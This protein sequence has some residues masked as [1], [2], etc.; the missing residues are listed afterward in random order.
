MIVVLAE[1]IVICDPLTLKERC[2]V[3]VPAPSDSSLPPIYALNDTT[4]AFADCSLNQVIQS[5][6]GR[7]E[8]DDQSYSGQMMNAAKQISK[9]VSSIGES[10]VSSFSSPSS[11]KR[12]GSVIEKGVVSIID[13]TKLPTSKD[14]VRSLHILLEFQ[15]NGVVNNSLLCKFLLY[16]F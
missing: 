5:C 9:T 14:S 15:R 16:C 6:G 3:V 13:T 12:N 1:S 11:E 8:C 7:M 4:L 10:L 2:S